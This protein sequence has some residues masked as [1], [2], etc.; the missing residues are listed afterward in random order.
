MTK[1]A[2]PLYGHDAQQAEFLSALASGRLHHAWIIEGPSGI[3]K[4]RFVTRLASVILGAK[5]SDADPAGAPDDDPVMQKVISSGHPDLKHVQRQLNDKGALKQDI[6]VDQ[7]RDLNAFFSLKPALGGWRIGILDSLDEMNVS[8]LN[9]VLKTLE[10]PPPKALIFLISHMT[11]PILPTIRSRC[12]TLRLQALNEGQTR[13]VLSES[14]TESTDAVVSLVKGRPGRAEELM[15]AK[16][17]AAAN[18]A[19]SLLKAMPRPNEAVLSQAI[20]SAA[21]DDTAFRVFASEVLDWLE[22]RTQSDAGWASTWFESQ[23]IVSSQRN[24]HMP[25]IQA[26]SKLVGCL[27]SAFHGR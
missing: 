9:A 18:A 22:A 21:E 17:L 24:L 11:T 2:L 16:V 27:Q 19:Q 6:A 4:A 10:E 7:I 12:Q 25:A 13:S 3:G 5:P 15:G 26:A 1:V 23:R 14:G 20:A 8:G